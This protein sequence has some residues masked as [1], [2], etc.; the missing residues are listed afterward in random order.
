MI[1]GRLRD[2]TATSPEICH[3]AR[4]AA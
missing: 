3:P 1:P 2:R 4:A